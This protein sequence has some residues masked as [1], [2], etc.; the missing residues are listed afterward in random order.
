[1]AVVAACLWFVTGCGGD[2]NDS[3]STSLSTPPGVTAPQVQRTAT[4]PGAAASKQAGPTTTVPGHPGA[5][6]LVRQ[7]GPFRDCLQRH[8]VQVPQPGVRDGPPRQQ[9]WGQSAAQR[10][11]QIRAR[12]ACIP[13]LPPQLRRF[14]ERLKKRYER[15]THGHAR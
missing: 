10:R 12:I 3:T 1:M 8:G 9:A 6:E 5:N 15:R 4:R 14:A 11:A 13:E 7:L 2:S